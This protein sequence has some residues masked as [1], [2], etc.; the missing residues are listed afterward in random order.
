M[1][2][3]FFWAEFERIWGVYYQ[4]GPASTQKKATQ[5]YPY[6][7]LNKPINSY[8][9]FNS[10]IATCGVKACSPFSTTI[11][12]ASLNAAVCLISFDDAPM[13]AV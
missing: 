12:L 13:L 8:L 6:G 7:L 2:E 11:S 3:M 5:H 10:L 4:V 1:R 9:L